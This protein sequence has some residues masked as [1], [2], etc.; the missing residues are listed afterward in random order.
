MKWSASALAIAFVAAAIVLTSSSAHAA[1]EIELSHDGRLWGD[2][3]T[4]P[5]FDS[6]LLWVPG[7]EQSVSFLVR[8]DGPDDAALTVEVRPT[9]T[10][11]LLADDHIELAVRTQGSDF[12][13]VRNGD[14]VSVQMP[15]DLAVGEA[16]EVD[17]HAV[18]APESSNASQRSEVAL[19]VVVTLSGDV[20]DGAGK[21]DEP[22]TAG[23]G[24][25]GTGSPGPWV[26]LWCAAALLVIGLLV[27]RR[28]TSEVAGG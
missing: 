25:P 16:A 24:L 15:A 22:A 12:Q 4:M 5:L 2:S 7:D 9:D 26:L 21:D 17:L 10:D 20:S 8:N 18:F 23:D 11:S 3:L 13:E 1:E 14:P 28:L 6:E 19:D 27:R